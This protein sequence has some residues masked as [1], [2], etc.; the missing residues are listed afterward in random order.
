M[1]AS[2][3]WLPSRS[4]NSRVISSNENPLLFYRTIAEYAS[5][6]LNDAGYL[7]FELHENYALETKAM[8]EGLGFGL[9]EIKEDLQGKDRML[10]AQWK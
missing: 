9:V 5:K 7:F 3:S 8:V 1:L 4:T 6:T 2:C 10:K